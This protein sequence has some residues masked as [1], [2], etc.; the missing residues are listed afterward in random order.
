MN[1]KYD[2]IIA[3]HLCLDIIPLFPDTGCRDIAG[4]MSSGKLVNVEN[5]MMS[6]GGPVSNTGLNMKKLGLDV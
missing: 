2:V 1:D 4:I 3:G 6:T 5:A